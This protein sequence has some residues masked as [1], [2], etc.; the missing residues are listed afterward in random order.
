MSTFPK[1]LITGATGG[2]GSAL[3]QQL[4]QRGIPFRALVRS[5]KEA[6]A[7]L[8]GVEVVRGDFNDPASLAR[9]LQGIERAFLLTSSSEQA[10]QQQLTFVAEARRAGVQHLVKLSQLAADLH[11]PVRFL[12]YHAVVEE[13]IL[14]TGLTYTF[15][16]PNLFMQGL[17]G[18]RSSIAQ[19]GLFFAAIGDA[20]ISLIDVHDIA[21]VAVEALTGEGHTGKTYTLTGSEALSHSEIA[22]QLSAVLHKPVHFQEVSPELMRE[23]LR[24]IGFPEWQAEGLVEDYAH[25][26][27]NEAAMVTYTVREVTGQAARTFQAFA[28]E[29]APLFRK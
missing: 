24:S 2:V 10:E 23:A 4:A 18:F 7:T 15:L 26:S 28:Q 29:F 11:S 9:A 13:A 22:Q 21:A 5:E 27:R 20:K 17:L 25:Y 3:T 6:L 19:Q 12:R 1:I 14:E 8:P 16:R